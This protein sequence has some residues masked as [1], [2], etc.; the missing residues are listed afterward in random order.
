MFVDCPRGG[1]SHTI[2]IGTHQAYP[3]RL[4]RGQ[5]KT[6]SVQVALVHLVR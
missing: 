5:H 6:D 4:A 1:I 3:I 2:E